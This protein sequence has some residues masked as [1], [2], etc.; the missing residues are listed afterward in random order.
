MIRVVN[1]IFFDPIAIVKSK[2]PEQFSEADSSRANL[3]DD[4]WRKPALFP[5]LVGVTTALRSAKGDEDIG[6]GPDLR[7]SST[8]YQRRS[9]ATKTSE[10]WA[11][12]LSSPPLTVTIHSNCNVFSAMRFPSESG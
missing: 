8:G 2:L 5:L 10:K 9:S 11:N 3:E 7:L 6:C 12:W 4:L 1:V